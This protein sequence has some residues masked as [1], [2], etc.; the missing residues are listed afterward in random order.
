SATGVF[1]AVGFFRVE[2]CPTQAVLP[3]VGLA[4]EKVIRDRCIS[5]LPAIMPH[6]CRLGKPRGQPGREGCKSARPQTL[7]SPLPSFGG[8]P[9]MQWSRQFPNVVVCL[10]MLCVF[11]CMA[12]PA[13][14]AERP[15]VLWITAEDMS[16]TL[17]CWGDSYASTPN[18][19]ALAD[20]S[21]MYTRAFATAPVC[22]P[23]RSCL[24]TGCRAMALG[25]QRLRSEFPI[26]DYMRGFPALL[27]EVG[28][29][30][31]NNAK[32]DYNTSNAQAI[33]KASWD[34][35]SRQAHWRDRGEEEPFFSVFNHM[36]SH[37]SRTMVWPYS[38][39][40]N[41]VQSRLDEDQIHDPLKAPIPPYYPDTPLMRTSVARYYD[42]VSVMDQEVGELLEQLEEDGLADD[43]IVFFYSDHGSGMPRHKRALLD[44]GMHVPLLIRFPPKYQHLAPAAPG[45]RIDRLVSFVDF[46]PT[47]LNLCGIE[48]PEFMQGKPF[49]G[50]DSGEKRQYVYGAR[51]RVDEV[52]DLARSVRDERYLYIRNFMPHLS[53]HQPSFYPDQGVI[54]AEITRYARKNS[55]RLTPAQAHYVADTRPVEE[56]YD[57]VADP[58]NEN[59]L[60]ESPDHQ[61]VLRRMRNALRKWMLD[62][63]DAG[64][65][66]EEQ[67]W[68]RLDGRTPYEL[69]QSPAEYPLKRLLRTAM[70]VGTDPES[71]DELVESLSDPEP[72][73]R[74]WAAMGLGAVSTK[75]DT[76][77]KALLTVLDDPSVAVRI[78][79]AYGLAKMGEFDVAL[80]VL[81]QALENKSV[82]AVLHA[83]RAIELL[84]SKARPA[85]QAMKQARQRAEGGGTIEM[86]VRFSVDS[87]L[88]DIE[89]KTP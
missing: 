42:C 60:A 83:A 10:V 25:T 2:T 85:A 63:R 67:V 14:A 73:V 36:T 4:A 49:L 53:Y 44:T 45:A 15:N 76:A 71:L 52:Y 11:G 18:I 20:Q 17:G 21:V 70:R 6:Q 33:I 41:D 3:L 79:A 39:F 34:E 48:I 51:D 64:F 61:K 43:T 40:Q 7:P 62:L 65:L 31:T 30:C 5:L 72:G 38:R 12:F 8:L 57:V 68:S 55:S 74:Y 56:L 80:P 13:L 37:Q 23:A 22:S 77:E 69:R 29:Y 16:P 27:R 46:A 78:E 47:V 82:D 54:R 84:G 19:D 24:I 75:A 89:D 58:W 35:S 9:T 28:Y 1:Q 50:N 32:T 87:F 26:P 81:E 66:P 59:N 88:D 86:F